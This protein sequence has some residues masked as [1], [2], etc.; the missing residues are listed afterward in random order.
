M[1][2]NT[3]RDAY[4]IDSFCEAHSISRASYYRLKAEGKAPREIHIGRK[5]IITREAAEDWRRSMESA[6]Q[7]AA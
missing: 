7:G 3:Q 1:T 2:S 4:S 6:S 5:P